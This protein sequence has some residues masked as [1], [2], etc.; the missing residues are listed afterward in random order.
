MQ[1]GPKDQSMRENQMDPKDPGPPHVLLSIQI[2]PRQEPAM[3][4]ANWVLNQLN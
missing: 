2:K 3:V 1:V 4:G